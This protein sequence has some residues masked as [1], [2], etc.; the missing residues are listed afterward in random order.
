[1]FL[2]SCV[3]SLSAVLW[4]SLYLCGKL[5]KASWCCFW[6][7]SLFLV[8]HW[9][10]CLWVKWWWWRMGKLDFT[11]LKVS[12]W[13]VLSWPGNSWTLNGD[14]WSI[15]IRKY[16][17]PTLIEQL[18]KKL[19]YLFQLFPKI[20]CCLDLLTATTCRNQSKVSPYDT[21]LNHVTHQS[22]KFSPREAGLIPGQF[23]NLSSISLMCSSFSSPLWL[24]W[25]VQACC[26]KARV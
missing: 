11:P 21:K 12:W 25:K 4:N 1:M 14:L 7:V 22:V 26:H 10:Q 16:P 24:D 6:G 2:N 23:R 17:P 8:H 13:C 3:L 15:E 18:F 5:T 9:F 20:I 19:F